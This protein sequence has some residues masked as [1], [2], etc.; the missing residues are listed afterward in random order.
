[1][2][3]AKVFSQKVIAWQL[4]ADTISPELTTKPHLQGLY[5]ELVDVIEEARSIQVNQETARAELMDTVRKRQ[6]LELKGD[7]I[8]S[9]LSS[10]L[11]G[12]LGPKNRQL[13]RYGVPPLAGPRRPEPGEPPPPP[14]EATAPE[15]EDSVLVE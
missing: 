15:G 6:V 3:T 10:F 8:R 12:E 11:R 7:G 1:M 2:R 4:L 13:V 14:V 9:R 5:N